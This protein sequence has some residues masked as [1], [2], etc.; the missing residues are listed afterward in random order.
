MENALLFLFLI[1]GL[2]IG[3]GTIPAMIDRQIPGYETFVAKMSIGTPPTTYKLQVSF[4]HDK[5]VLYDR[6]NI[7]SV[8][9]S[10]EFGGN[11]VIRVGGK[12]Y[13]VPVVVDP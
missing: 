6:L 12:S 9:F 7:N 3:H 4:A 5:I 13:R 11:D 2:C 8:S 1:T 10:G